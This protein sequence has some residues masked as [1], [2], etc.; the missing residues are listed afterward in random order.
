MS[1]KLDIA[2]VSERRREIKRKAVELMG[3]KCEIC[4]YDKCITALHFH[5]K[6]PD[7]KDF[8]ISRSI[9]SWEKIVE[10]IQK[11]SLLCSNCHA[12]IHFQLNLPEILCKE[13]LVNA[14]KRPQKIQK[15]CECCLVKF[16]VAP[17]HSYQKCCSRKCSGQCQNKTN[18]PN[19]D[20]L[21][22][23]IKTSSVAQVARELKVTGNSITKRLKKHGVFYTHKPKR[24]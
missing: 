6:N 23:K 14:E 20:V 17:S 9:K 19:D 1:S 12:E 10:E 7:Q 2:R 13:K 21:I 8:S 4:G 24:Q 11:C 15:T 18:W 22:S 16:Y 3:G 5:H